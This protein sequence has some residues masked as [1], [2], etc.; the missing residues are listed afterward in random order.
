MD[1]EHFGFS[2]SFS[3]SFSC[4][5]F[6][7]FLFSLIYLNS[8]VYSNTKLG[9]RGGKKLGKIS[10]IV[11]TFSLAPLQSLAPSISRNFAEKHWITSHGIEAFEAPSWVSQS[12]VIVVQ[13]LYFWFVSLFRFFAFSPYLLGLPSLIDFLVLISVMTE[14]RK[15]GNSNDVRNGS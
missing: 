2:W 12:C 6:Q 14:L 13:D 1:E 9:R 15:E 8:I 11:V 5:L 7:S 3:F 10:S 4:I